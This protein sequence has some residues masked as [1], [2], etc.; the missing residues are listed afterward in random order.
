LWDS[1]TSTGRLFHEELKIPACRMARAIRQAE[2]GT[3][4]PEVCRKGGI[5]EQTFYRR[6]KKHAGMGIAEVRKVRIL[7]EE[8]RQ[9]RQL[10]AD[11]SLDKQMLRDVPRRTG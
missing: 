4:V 5:A 7:E 10:V 1:H 6:K 11:L 8:N 9:L 3:P 2:S